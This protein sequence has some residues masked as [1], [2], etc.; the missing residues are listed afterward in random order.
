[1]IDNI[2]R[3][4]FWG[5]DAI[6]LRSHERIMT[7][8]GRE[9]GYLTLGIT[10][11]NRLV[12]DE[13]KSYN[14]IVDTVRIIIRDHSNINQAPLREWGKMCCI[15]ECDF[16]HYIKQIYIETLQRKRREE[17]IKPHKFVW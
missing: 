17:L 8:Y 10:P 4:F 12:P 15:K 7:V 11:K 14:G 1:M 2:F 6:E 16:D 5:I 9:V 13:L 3:K